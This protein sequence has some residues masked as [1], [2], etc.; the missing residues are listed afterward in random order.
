MRRVKRF[1]YV[2]AVV[3]LALSLLLGCRVSRLLLSSHPSGSTRPRSSTTPVTTPHSKTSTKAQLLHL[4]G[5][6]VIPAIG[7]N[8]PIEPGR[9]TRICGSDW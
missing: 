4:S 2:F 5:T 9:D 7:V 1:W 3:V 6:L 8:A